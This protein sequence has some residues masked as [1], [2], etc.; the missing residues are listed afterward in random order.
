MNT[1]PMNPE[2]QRIAIAEECGVRPIPDGWTV[3]H[4]GRKTVMLSSWLEEE[5]K[6]W[7]KEHPDLAAE[8]WVVRRSEHY[9]DYLNDLNAMHEAENSLSPEQIADYALTLCDM[10]HVPD[11]DPEFCVPQWPAIN[12]PP[13]IRAE[14]FLRTLNLWEEA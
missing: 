7:L 9:P 12:A 3:Y 14:A 2:K 1:K 5:C 10:L 6:R 8:G 4:P 13:E 11:F